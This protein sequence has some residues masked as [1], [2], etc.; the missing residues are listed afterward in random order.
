[1]S[2]RRSFIKGLSY[3]V[4]GL[5]LAGQLA[6]LQATDWSDWLDIT[7]LYPENNLGKINFNCGSAGVQPIV[8]LEVFKQHQRALAAYAPYEVYAEHHDII[9][10]SKRRLAA[11]VNVEPEEIALVR[12]TT[13]AINHILY[14]IL[15][16]KGD[17][18]VISNVDYPSVWNTV[19]RLKSRYG[20]V[21][22][23]VSLDLNLD[24][25]ATI[26]SRYEAAVSKKTKLLIGTHMTHREGQIMPVAKISAIG[27]NYGVDVLIDGAH[28]VGHFPIDIKSIGCQYYATSLHKWLSA[29]LGSGMIYVQQE[30]IGALHPPT[31]YAPAQQNNMSKFSM[32]GTFAFEKW[33]TLNTVL[34][35]QDNIGIEAK[36]QRLRAMSTRFRQG[37]ADV[38][39]LI[40]AGNQ[41][42]YGGINAFR[43]TSINNAKLKTHLMDNYGFHI[44]KVGVGDEQILFL[45]ASFNLHLT[46]QNVDDLVMGIKQYV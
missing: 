29:P 41:K 10:L 32:I 2:S 36:A 24:N 4:A 44:K 11:N 28:A 19:R 22:R 25:E 27:T 17:E 20:V 30:S 45:R 13:E 34:D 7:G 5:P 42:D 6:R 31:S 16:K 43:V 39:E 15:W 18:I 8:V 33:M 14:G 9:E 46:D 21:I 37:L 23:K 38:P 26:V 3:S 1:M 40:F 35:F 12:N